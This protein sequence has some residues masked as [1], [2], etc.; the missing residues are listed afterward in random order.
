MVFDV[1]LYCI[2][3][4]QTVGGRGKCCARKWL[5]LSSIMSHVRFRMFLQAQPLLNCM[6][7]QYVLARLFSKTTISKESF[8]VY[9]VQFQYRDNIF[10]YRDSHYKNKRDVRRCH[11]CIPGQRHLYIEMTLKAHF[12]PVSCVYVRSWSNNNAKRSLIL[13]SNRNHDLIL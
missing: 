13:S 12:T 2:N 9:K 3:G 4:M 10:M 8:F 11:L 1:Q 5:L 7:W 6:K